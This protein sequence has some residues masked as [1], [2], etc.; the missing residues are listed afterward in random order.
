MH[1]F[2]QRGRAAIWIDGAIDPSVAM[3]TGDHPLGNGIGARDFADNIPDGAQ[4]KVLLQMH[5]DPHRSR[6]DVVR[7]G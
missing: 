3:I 6:A 5:F 7:K 2:Q 1:R 4:L